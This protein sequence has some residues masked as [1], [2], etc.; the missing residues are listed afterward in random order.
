M[1]NFGLLVTS[2]SGHPKLIN[3]KFVL[4]GDAVNFGCVARVDGGAFN[5]FVRIFGPKSNFELNDG[6]WFK[7]SDDVTM[8]PGPDWSLLGRSYH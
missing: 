3:F 8:S 4:S 7:I 1:E 6:S 5:T 2:R